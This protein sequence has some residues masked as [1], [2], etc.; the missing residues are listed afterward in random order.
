[1]A[2]RMAHLLQFHRLGTDP[3]IFPADDPSV[4]SGNSPLKREIAK[5]ILAYL[6]FLDSIIASSSATLPLIHASTCEA[7]SLPKRIVLILSEDN[8]EMVTNINDSDIPL[9]GPIAAGYSENTMTDLSIEIV[10]SQYSQL[11]CA[12]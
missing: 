7:I 5:R 9:D 4:P 6:V 11:H 12:D 10:R 8:T 3:N 1:M 2:I